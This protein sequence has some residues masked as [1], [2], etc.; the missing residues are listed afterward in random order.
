MTTSEPKVDPRGWYELKA[1]AEALE[2]SKSTLTRAM[3]CTDRD[4]GIAFKIRKSNGR[5]II[6][7][8][9]IINY[10]RFTY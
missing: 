1:A 4:R 8:Q 9:S 6:Q 5:R 7:G 10:W 3:S 2:V